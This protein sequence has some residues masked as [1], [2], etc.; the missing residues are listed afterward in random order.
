MAARVMTLEEATGASAPVATYTINE[1]SWPMRVEHLSPASIGKFLE[2]PEKW[3][4]HYVSRERDPIVGYWL[5]R[6]SVN[7]RAVDWALK[8]KMETGELPSLDAVMERF[9]MEWSDELEK[10]GGAESVAWEDTTPD[11][12]KDETARLV[13]VYHQQVS[14]SLNPIALEAK[15]LFDTPG[16]PIPTLM[17]I[18]IEEQHRLIDRKE[19]AARTRTPKADW[20]MKGGLYSAAKRKPIEFH[21]STKTK[22][23]AVYTAAD[24]PGLLVPAWREARAHSYISRVFSEIQNLYTSFGPDETWNGATMHPFACSYCSFKASCGWW[25]E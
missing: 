19:T 6:G 21:V 18:D 23:P 9:D 14:P 13:G 22:T 10:R 17:Y 4:K 20:I 3:R 25:S 7:H 1:A 24:D 16:V 15:T 11:A 5:F 2:C 12:V 8:E